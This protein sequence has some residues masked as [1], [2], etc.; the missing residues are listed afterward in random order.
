VG[1]NS[2]SL[3]I[4]LLTC[5][6][7]IIADNYVFSYS[8]FGIDTAKWKDIKKDGKIIHKGWELDYT[9][10]RKY[11]ADKF[12]VTKAFIFIGYVKDNEKLYR[13]LKTAGYELVF[14]PTVKDCNGKIKG[15]IDAELVLHTAAIEFNNYD[16]AI[17][18]SGDGDFHCLLEFLEQKDKLESLIIPNQRR[19]S[20]LLKKFELYI[21]FIIR[22]KGKLA[23][24]EHKKKELKR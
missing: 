12:R 20:S 21:M 8:I 16:K 18:V 22:E 2:L 3:C 10:F 5:F 6:R 13:R 19:M 17:I 9:K 24:T 7:V 1:T 23:A 4:I 11:L 14:K 15:N